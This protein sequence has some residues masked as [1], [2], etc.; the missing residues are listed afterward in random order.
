MVC[1][2]SQRPFQKRLEGTS[3]AQEGTSTITADPRYDDFFTHLHVTPETHRAILPE[4]GDAARGPTQRGTSVTRREGIL[5]T[6]PRAKEHPCGEKTYIKTTN[7]HTPSC[8]TKN[9]RTYC[10]HG[11]DRLAFPVMFGC[12][13]FFG[14]QRLGV[15]S[16]SNNSHLMQLY[17]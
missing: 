6:Q 15:Q 10:H 2:C 17:A 14:A 11:S 3:S 5:P 12:S 16:V 4:H 8:R 7:C 1:L 9:K 13:F